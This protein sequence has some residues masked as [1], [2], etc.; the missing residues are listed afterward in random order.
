MDVIG[1]RIGAGTK[2]RR[3]RK[4]VSTG[5]DVQANHEGLTPGGAALVRNYVETAPL[6]WFPSNF[7]L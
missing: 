6:I 7:S 1:H 5:D 2:G 4:N 3:R